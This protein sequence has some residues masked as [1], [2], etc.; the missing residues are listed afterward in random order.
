MKR[1]KQI[2]ASLLSALTALSVNIAPVIAD[3]TFNITIVPKD[4][5]NHTYEAYQIL[6]FN[7]ES[8]STEPIP[9]TNSYEWGS[10]I[11]A[12]GEAN[13]N[14]EII[15]T[16]TNGD[17]KTIPAADGNGM[18]ADK[19]E[20]VRDQKEGTA[21]TAQT[22]IGAF[23]SAFG[24]FEAD[25]SQARELAALYGR[26]L[27]ST[28]YT[29]SKA[30]DGSYQFTSL[31]SGYYLIRD[32]NGSQDGKTGAN[33]RYILVSLVKD[34]T[35][36]NAIQS[37]SS[38]P[39][40]EK[41]VYEPEYGRNDNSIINNVSLGQG[42]NDIADYDIGEEI[43]FEVLGTVAENYE[44]YEAYFYEISDTII[45]GLEYSNSGNWVL[46]YAN[47][48]DGY[49]KWT[50][51]AAGNYQLVV[52]PKTF[53]LTFPVEE[54]TE[55]ALAK[56][57][58]KAVA[59]INK[60]SVLRLTYF[61]RL[62]GDPTIGINADGNANTN[63]AVIKFSNNPNTK[64]YGNTGTTPPSK[65]IVFTYEI[66][67][68]KTDSKTTPLPNAYFV[69]KDSAGNFLKETS[70]TDG[71]SYSWIQVDEPT[72]Q[73]RSNLV[74]YYTDKG[75][76]IFTTSNEGKFSVSGIDD[77]TYTAVEIQAPKG[78]SLAQD[79]EITMTATYL[80]DTD[81]QKWDGIDKNA[82]TNFSYSIN[83]GQSITPRTLPYGTAKATIVDMKG[84]VL[85]STGGIG[86]TIFYVLGGILVAGAGILLITKKRMQ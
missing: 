80:T 62:T 51:I 43:K 26:H 46:E 28:T 17:W 21:A 3:Q 58:L 27:R 16:Y 19:F 32:R 4:S 13:L 73:D 81:R 55:P 25:S 54:A 8:D 48:A 60:T 37:K 36:E 12:T 1:F 47:A 70:S 72:A 64:G 78:Y 57:G 74:K 82:L 68:L 77:G 84:T 76:K 24:S 50:T 44:D 33:T 65:T 11:Q 9:D 63:S 15:N 86:T 53:S 83:R 66:E 52:Q 31:P 35:G 14:A 5:S 49:Q 20:Y 75:V 69:I 7:V 30:T 23:M 45:G 40:V 85:P 38:M 56:K 29:A 61:A 59:D 41:K 18:V 6:T 39:S 79:T 34:Y 22:M 10:G 71:K 2:A 42:F 67:I